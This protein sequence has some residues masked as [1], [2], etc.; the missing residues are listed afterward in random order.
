MTILVSIGKNKNRIIAS[1]SL[2]GL[3]LF[4]PGCGLLDKDARTRF[5]NL[6]ELNKKMQHGISDYYTEE[7]WNSMRREHREDLEIIRA[8]REELSLD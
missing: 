2:L 6:L 3:A 8:Y 5:L 4:Q 1:C 7:E